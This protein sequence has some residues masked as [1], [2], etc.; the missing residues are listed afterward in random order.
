MFLHVL[1]IL[2]FFIIFSCTIVKF[3]NGYLL[4]LIK[5]AHLKI[6]CDHFITSILY[7]AC[8]QPNSYWRWWCGWWKGC[9]Y[10]HENNEIGDYDQ[11]PKFPLLNKFLRYCRW[12]KALFSWGISNHLEVM[13]WWY[14]TISVLNQFP[15]NH[16]KFLFLFLFFNIFENAS[17]F[18]FWTVKATSTISMAYAIIYTSSPNKH[19]IKV[20]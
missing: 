15:R 7:H 2:I 10:S 8:N 5:C 18:N 16:Q 4:Y 6:N 17:H 13:V 9:E 19:W 11:I 12:T 3:H 14:I 1:K 20:Y